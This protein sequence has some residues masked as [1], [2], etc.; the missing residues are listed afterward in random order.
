MG[1]LG[2]AGSFRELLVYKKARAIAKEIFDLSKGFPKEEM[3]SL[4]DQVRRS[5]RSIGAQIAEA[6]GK[7]RYERH[8]ISKLT[9]A[10]GEQLESQH[11]IEVA[12]DCGYLT[13]SQVGQLNDDLSEIGR[14]LSS[15]INKAEQFCGIVRSSVGLENR[16]PTDH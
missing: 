15:M 14:M 6:W 3:Y 10:D 16:S 7:R 4:T 13:A 11:W 8:F 12:G 5:S 1:G 9:D 2:H